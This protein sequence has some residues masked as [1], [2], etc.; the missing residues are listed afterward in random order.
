MNIVNVMRAERPASRPI[1]LRFMLCSTP[2]RDTEVCS[3]LYRWPMP[4]TWFP[5]RLLAFLTGILAL[6]F[7]TLGAG[8]AAARAEQIPVI[9]VPG[10]EPADLQDVPGRGAV[11]PLLPPPP[12]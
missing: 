12:P 7:L 11:S 1:A 9:V 2:P 6:A 8:Q 10:L 4:P 3:R 5:L